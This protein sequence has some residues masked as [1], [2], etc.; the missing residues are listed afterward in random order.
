[1]LRFIFAQMGENSLARLMSCCVTPRFDF[2]IFSSPLSTCFCFNSGG[3][4][5]TN[6]LYSI[7]FKDL[8]LGALS[9]S[10]Y[11]VSLSFEGT[12]KNDFVLVLLWNRQY[13]S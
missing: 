13:R 10:N 8:F 1:M 3:L 11:P 5:S 12:G 2:C 9:E 7:I 4:S 6:L